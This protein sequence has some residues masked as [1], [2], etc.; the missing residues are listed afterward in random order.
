MIYLFHSLIRNKEEREER[1]E[2][3]KPLI[4]GER[5][6]LAKRNLEIDEVLFLPSI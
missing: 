1:E 4:S 3:R 6:K 2:K 5:G